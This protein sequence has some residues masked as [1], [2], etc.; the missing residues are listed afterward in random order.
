MNNVSVDILNVAN[1][2]RQR[3]G[4]TSVINLGE[5]IFG[6]IEGENPSGSVKDRAAFYIVVRALES[7]ELKEGGTVVE[8][9]SGNMGISLAYVARE[10]GLKA[11][12]CMPESMS[13]ERRKMI[14]DYGAELVLTPTSEGMAGAVEAAKRISEERGAFIANQ[15]ANPA[16]IEAHFETT[17]PELFS[18]VNDIKYIV[19]GVGSGGTAMGI[20]RYIEENDL[21]CRLVAVEPSSSP[22]MSKGYAGAHKI[23]GIGANFLPKLIHVCKFDKIMTADNDESF[24]AVKELY[25][26]FGIKCG[27]SSGA[28]YSVAKRLRG[29]VGGNIAVILPDNGDRYSVDL[30]L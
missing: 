19:A 9:T 22:L 15:F 28:A 17:A 27:I 6:K 10:L 7:G 16:S 1:S 11:V 23:Q 18:Q 4:H 3:I 24:A 25:K 29:E 13:V 12:L 21:D 30:F 2:L 26:N 14:A 20:A 8:A 5:S